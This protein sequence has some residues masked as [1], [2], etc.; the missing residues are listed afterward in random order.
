[1]R[2]G[3][4]E[5][6]EDSEVA[7][8]H[9]VSAFD[10]ALKAAEGLEGV[11]IGMAEGGIVLDGLVEVLGVSKVVV[12]AFDLVL[13]ELGFDAAEA[14]LGPL[15]GDEGIDQRALVG[16]GGPVVEQEF[17]GKGLEFAGIFAANDVRPGVDAG[18]EGVQRGGGF[19]FGGSGAGRFLGITAVGFNLTESRHKWFRGGQGD[20][21]GRPILI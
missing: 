14:A 3:F 16:V 13:P 2:G 15:G 8:V 9:A 18:F 11:L 5:V 7:E 17:G 10:A 19:A 20:A 1:M 21:V 12:E 6:L 4:L